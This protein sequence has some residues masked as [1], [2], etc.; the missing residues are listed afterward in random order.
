M[1]AILLAGGF[2]TRLRPI[3]D[4]I[5]KCLVPIKGKPLLQIWMERLTSSGIK[6][7]LVNTHYLSE[8]V[9]LFIKN[10]AF[11]NQV[12]ISYEPVLLG[13]AGTLA[14]NYGFFEGEDGLLI[15]ADNYCLADFS[16]FIEIHNNRPQECMMTMMAFRT[17]SPSSCGILEV[18]ERG[19]L[20]GFHEKIA[21]PP[22]NLANGAIYILSKELLRR[23]PDM[24]VSD[25]STGIIPEYLGKIFVCETKKTLADIGN[26]QTYLN[27]KYRG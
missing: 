19:I 22:G 1:K 24:K 16:E 27:F 20:K 3:T 13:T 10:S 12:T 18:D 8:Q 2:G 17:D 4:T 9:D 11:A 26:V 15:H 6:S 5:P 21:N 25:F 14:A 7:F 23:I